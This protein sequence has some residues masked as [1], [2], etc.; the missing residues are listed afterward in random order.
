MNHCLQSTHSKSFDL[1]MW[2]GRIIALTH[3]LRSRMT[4]QYIRSEFNPA[5]PFTRRMK[6]GGHHIRV[7]H[8]LSRFISTQASCRRRG[9]EVVKD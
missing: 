2:I 7:L 3:N 4:A 9:V 6:L 5:D 1:N 8:A